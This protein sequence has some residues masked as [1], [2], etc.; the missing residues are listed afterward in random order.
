LQRLLSAEAFPDPALVETLTRQVAPMLDSLERAEAQAGRLNRLI[1]DIVEVARIQSHQLKLVPIKANLAELLREM[2]AEPRLAW[3]TR[4]I[5]LDVPD[6]AVIVEIDEGRIE[7]VVINYV[8]NALKYSPADRPITVSLRVENQHARVSVQ[9]EGPGLPPQEL[10]RIWE[11]FYRVR[12][13]EAQEGSSGGLGL[14]LSICR[15]IVQEHGGQV[16]VE[17]TPGTGSTFWF[18]LP[19]RTAVSAACSSTILV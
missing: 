14:G 7:Q 8:T 19:L 16:G 1:E 2:V 9:D 12:G 11:R 17:S 18:S 10:A 4:A 6:E 3:P 13:I 15:S 5:L